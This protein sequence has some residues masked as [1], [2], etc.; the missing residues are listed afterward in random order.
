[1]AAN[2]PA[3]AAS[4]ATPA[5]VPLAAPPLELELKA[6]SQSYDSQLGR[7]VATGLSLIHI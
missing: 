7:F 1:M 2:P 5:S 6:D 3:K 4:K